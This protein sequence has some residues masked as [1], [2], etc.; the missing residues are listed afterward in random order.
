MTE[1]TL[2]RAHAELIREC[3][4]GG[5]IE[6]RVQTG[7]KHYK[8][9]GPLEKLPK[10]DRLYIGILPRI[11]PERNEYVPSSLFFLDLD[12]VEEENHLALVDKVLEV[13][14]Q[15]KI[16]PRE[17]VH[18]GGG[19]HVYFVASRPLT[20]EERRV[21]VR[22]YTKEFKKRGAPGIPDPAVGDMA[23]IAGLWGSQNAKHKKMVTPIYTN[24]GAQ[25]VQPKCA[26]KDPVKVHE[27]SLMKFR[28]GANPRYYSQYYLYRLA[29]EIPDHWCPLEVYN[30]LREAAE[31][32]AG[33]TGNI[34]E[35]ISAFTIVSA[36]KM[37][38]LSV[39]GDRTKNPPPGRRRMYAYHRLASVVE[40]FPSAQNLQR[41]A[42]AMKLEL[43]EWVTE[44][45]GQIEDIVKSLVRARLT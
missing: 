44:E 39:R 24:P 21:T 1:L 16:E 37:Q 35:A 12:K 45:P 27:K 40:A 11:K 38:K 29:D 34:D 31:E 41:F 4:E 18:S 2:A 6:F 25:K 32:T 17:I 36:T 26:V 42:E 30:L 15:L 8:F 10:A 28:K 7:S 5:C 23:R 20:K 3:G 19:L 43:C 13:S 14:D 33:Q 9:Y 22:H